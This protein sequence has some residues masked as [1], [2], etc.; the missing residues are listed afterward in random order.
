VLTVKNGLDPHMIIELKDGL[1]LLAGYFCGF[2]EYQ[3]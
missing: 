3:P 1:I 2:A